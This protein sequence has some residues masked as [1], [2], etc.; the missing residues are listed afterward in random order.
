MPRTA[1]AGNNLIQRLGK[2]SK[3][4]IT[5]NDYIPKSQGDVLD[6]PLCLS[7]F[8][9]S[10]MVRLAWCSHRCCESCL[11]QYLAI[12]IFEARVPVN[13]PVCHESMHPSVGTWGPV[14]QPKK[15]LCRSTPGVT[16][17]FIINSVNDL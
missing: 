17:L 16:R 1:I 4:I 5:Y 13:C 6:C 7:T 8:N 15:P 12:E 3:Y 2:R 9:A 10:T 11:R 14:L